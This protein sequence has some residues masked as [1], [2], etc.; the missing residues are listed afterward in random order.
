[1]KIEIPK[2]EELEEVNK[3]ARQ[4]HELHVGWRPD[5][6]KSVHYVIEKERFESLIEDKKIYVMRDE[7]KIV[8]YVTIEIKERNSTGMH[9]RKILD[10][11]AIC[12]DNNYRGKG[13]GT[14]LINYIIDLGKKEKCTDLYLSVN[15]ENTDAIKLYEKIG[16]R[17]KNISYSMKI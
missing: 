16:M 8:G 2:K 1:M 9:Y 17:V 14:E 3:I 10:L 12:I 15:E 11:D 13:L 6:F 4:V 7:D 5:I